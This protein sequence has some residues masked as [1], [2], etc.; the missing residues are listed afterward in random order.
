MIAQIKNKTN[1]SIVILKG[2]SRLKKSDR[3]DQIFSFK[4]INDEVLQ[5]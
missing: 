4:K 3:S 2:I 1:Q 5:A